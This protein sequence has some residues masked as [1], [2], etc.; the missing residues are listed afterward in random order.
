MGTLSHAAI[1]LPQA[2]QWEPGKARFS[3]RGSRWMTTFRKL[4]KSSPSATAT[5]VRKTGGNSA[6]DGNAD[7]A[8]ATVQRGAGEATNVS[9]PWHSPAQLSRVFSGTLRPGRDIAW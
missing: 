3:P 1:G 2:G 4:P 9:F 7:N 5:A 8:S 6:S